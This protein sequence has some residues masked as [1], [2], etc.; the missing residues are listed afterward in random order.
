MMDVGHDASWP[1]TFGRDIGAFSMDMPAPNLAEAAASARIPV[2]SHNEWDP[3]EE[4]IVGRLEGAVIPSNHPVVA[5]TFRASPPGPR[6]WSRVSLSGPS[7][8]TRRNASSTVSS[9]CPIARRHRAAPDAST[10]A[11]KWRAGLV[12]ARLLQF[13]PA[14][15]HAGRW[16]RDHRN[17]NGL[18]VP[19]FRDPLLSPLLKDYFRR[20]ARWT[21]APRPQLIDELYNPIFT[22][23]SRA[24]RSLYSH[25][26][27]AGFR[28]RG[29]LPLR[30]RSFRHAQQCD[31]RL[32]HRMA[33][34]PSWRRLSHPRDREPL[35]QSDAY[36]HDDPAAR[37][38][39]F[40]VNPEYVDSE[41]LP[42]ILK[43]WDIL[44]APE[45]DPIEDRILK[46][47]SLCGKWLNMNVLMIDEKRVIVDPHHKATMK[48]MKDGGWSP[49]PARSALRGLWRLVPLRDAGRAAARRAR[50]LFLTGWRPS[51][52]TR[53]AIAIGPLLTQCGSRGRE[54]L[55][56][57]LAESHRLLNS[58]L[59][60]FRVLSPTANSVIS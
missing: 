2:N 39:Q 37:P 56:V 43:K 60:S 24:S 49:F 34:P 5:C 55:D 53:Q 36:R 16:R 32:R 6:R 52:G 42:P 51:N 30:P 45:P 48:A 58:S 8:S 9:R 47:T 35:P 10:I 13:L 31:Q 12:V 18:A 19:L 41:R 59:S 7:P 11:R 29:F 23:P 46:I 1:T 27:R 15:Q 22:S 3:L 44:V 54:R 20:G 57:T 26:F 14:R 33:T 17:A 21:A 50:E 4:M 40:L 38:R 28:R 25:G